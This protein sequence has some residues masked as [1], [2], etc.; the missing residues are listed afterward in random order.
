VLHFDV[1]EYGAGNRDVQLAAGDGQLGGYGQ[2][3]V[4]RGAVPVFF[5]ALVLDRFGLGVVAALVTL[6]RVV[7]ENQ[8]PATERLICTSTPDGSPSTRAP[9]VNR[10]RPRRSGRGIEAWNALSSSSNP[11]NSN[12]RPVGSYLAASPM[13][14]TLSTQK[15]TRSHGHFHFI[16]GHLSASR[17]GG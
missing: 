9:Q 17:H 8:L 7:A 12:R 14:G 3:D 11:L 16:I 15:T 10:R 5:L 2:P 13:P 4:S 6:A 1:S